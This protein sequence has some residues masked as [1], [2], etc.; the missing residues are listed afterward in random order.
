M[1]KS[2][3]DKTQ[4]PQ[5]VRSSNDF[6]DSLVQHLF[7]HQRQEVKVPE[8]FMENLM[9]KIEER[10]QQEPGIPLPGQAEPQKEQPGCE[11]RDIGGHKLMEATVN[12]SKDATAFVQEARNNGSDVIA[13]SAPGVV[14]MSGDSKVMQQSINQFGAQKQ[15]INLDDGST[16]SCLVPK[17]GQSLETLVNEAV[18]QY[19]RQVALEFHEQSVAHALR[20]AEQNGITEKTGITIAK[21]HGL[22][23]SEAATMVEAVGSSHNNTIVTHADGVKMD[24][25]V[26]KNSS[27]GQSLMNRYADKMT[28]S[29][30]QNVATFKFDSK[31]EALSFVNDAN[32][33]GVELNELDKNN[34]DEVSVDD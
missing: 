4:K 6:T 18:A 14:L 31:Q 26:S 17:P 28:D 5:K 27:L 12:S 2:N 15:E 16:V 19:E 11:T 25:M 10:R 9:K 20:V 21:A 33:M 3:Q 24:V 29:P 7:E 32:Q 13:V 23:L 30:D 34:M 22:S 8:N 1:G